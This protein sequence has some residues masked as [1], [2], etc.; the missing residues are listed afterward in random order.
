VLF[1]VSKLE[2]LVFNLQ[3]W[4]RLRRCCLKLGLTRIKHAL[5]ALLNKLVFIDS[6]INLVLRFN[7]LGTNFFWHVL[8]V[9]DLVLLNNLGD[10]IIR[11]FRFP[12]VSVNYLSSELGG[13]K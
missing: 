11:H 8:S 5:N 7:L 2:R 12:T 6:G 3:I 1:H 13:K 4:F 10:C 9:F